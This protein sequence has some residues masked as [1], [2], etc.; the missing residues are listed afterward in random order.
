MVQAQKIPDPRLH[1]GRVSGA[2]DPLR[3]SGIIEWLL[4][5]QESFIGSSYYYIREE[6]EG[7][8]LCCLSITGGCLYS[9]DVIDHIGYGITGEDIDDAIRN[10]SCDPEIPGHFH[11]NI[12][13]EHKLRTLLDIET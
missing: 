2:D 8:V 11:I 10:T 12:H 6:Q 3:Y 7:C 9:V 13:I 5:R 4:D 1:P